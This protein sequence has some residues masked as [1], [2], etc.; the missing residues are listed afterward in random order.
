MK[1]EILELISVFL[2]DRGYKVDYDDG[3]IYVDNLRIL[4]AE[5]K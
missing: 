1:N 5:D 4:V 3:A 2:E